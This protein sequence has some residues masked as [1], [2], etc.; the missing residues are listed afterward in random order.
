[1]K[2]KISI[3]LVVDNSSLRCRLRTI[4]AKADDIEVIGDYSSIEECLPKIEM[5]SPDM[6]IL[7]TKMPGMS[8]I[9]AAHR[10]RNGPRYDGAII[11]L[12]E[13]VDDVFDNLEDSV[14]DYYF[15][16][17]KHLPQLAQL[18]RQVS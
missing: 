3:L 13:S 5:T 14:V 17:D 8:G 1:M 18:V 6:V 9:E 12:A 4:L 7:D 16:K 2:N 11:M 10:L 15:V